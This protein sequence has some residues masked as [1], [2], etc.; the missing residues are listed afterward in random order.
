MTASV[1]ETPNIASGPLHAV[2]F[3]GPTHQKV[4]TCADVSLLSL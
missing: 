2:E 1:K 4:N 3:G